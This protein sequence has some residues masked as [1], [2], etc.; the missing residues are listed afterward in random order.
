MVAK[1]PALNGTQGSSVRIPLGVQ[2]Y[3]IVFSLLIVRLV[4]G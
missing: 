4:T 3:A 2:M 1:H